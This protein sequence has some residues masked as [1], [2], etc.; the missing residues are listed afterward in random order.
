[1]EKR[2]LVRAPQK[3]ASDKNPT[4]ET[5]A[6]WIHARRL[7][8]EYPKSSKNCGKWLI[9]EHVDKIDDVWRKIRLATEAGL[10]GGAAKVATARSSPNATN[11][12][13]KVIC[14][15]SYDYTDKDDVMRIRGELRNIGIERKI[16]YKTDKATLAG[17]YKIKGD[18]GIST[19]CD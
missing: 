13:V 11:D 15:Y 1:M 7:S 19:Y 10:L 4:E 3:L 16:P 18:S 12:K 5:D 8:G 9:H 14:V 6:Y 17:K 2:S